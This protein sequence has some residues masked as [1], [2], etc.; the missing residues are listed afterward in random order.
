MTL[1]FGTVLILMELGLLGKVA[2]VTGSSQGI[3]YATA[4]RFAEAGAFVAVTYRHEEA[5]AQ[6]LVSEIQAKCKDAVA[7]FLDLAS[8]D[9]IGGAVRTVIARWGTVDVLVNNAIQWGS[10]PISES[11]AFEDYPDAEWRSLFRINIE[12]V[13]AITQAVVPYMRAR[14]PGRDR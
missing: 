3:G 9:S 6:A 10:T 5:R 8:S 7:V 4:W 2:M 11:P 14:H 12:G 1:I 13:Y